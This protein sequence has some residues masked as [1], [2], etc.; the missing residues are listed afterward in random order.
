MRTLSKVLVLIP[1]LLSI[2]QVAQAQPP[3]V[4]APLDPFS[5]VLLGGVAAVGAR[6][7]YNSRRG[8]K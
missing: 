6:K 3:P 1:L 4:S 2:A 8:K 5:W 7:Y